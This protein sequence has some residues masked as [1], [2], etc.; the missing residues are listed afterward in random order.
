MSFSYEQSHVYWDGG[1][2]TEMQKLGILGDPVLANLSQPEEVIKIHQ[3]Y[4]NAGANIITTN[5]FGAYRHKYENFA[6]IITAAIANAHASINLVQDVSLTFNLGSTG[7]M[8]EPY[9][10][11]TVEECASIYAA[12]LDCAVKNGLNCVLFETMMDLNE[13]EIAVL[14]AKKRGMY[15]AATMSFEPNGR[16]LY[17]TSLQ[18]MVEC[19]Q[20]IGAETIGMNC[21]QGLDDYKKFVPELIKLLE[22]FNLHA[23]VQPNAGLPEMVDGKPQYNILPQEY[24]SFMAGIAIQGVKFLGGCCGT[25]PAHIA[26]MVEMCSQL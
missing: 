7:L 23:L 16:T 18:E 5:T 2:G 8:L 24:A 4:V 21:G 3:S 22:P 6:E 15:V 20:R 11:T 9:G 26:A 14:E 13:L 25:T 19:L 17:G 1:T 10:D 12:S